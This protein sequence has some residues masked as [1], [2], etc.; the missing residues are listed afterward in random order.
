MERNGDIV[1][2][3]AREIAEMLARGEGRTDWAKVDATTQEE[4]ERQ[5]AEDDAELGIIW[6]DEPIV[7]LPAPR[8]AVHLAVDADVLDWF[9]SLGPG[10]RAR[11][12]AALRE[13]MASR[14]PAAG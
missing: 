12:N 13:F 10:Y 7:G 8:E 9:R 11:M 2:Y 5:A 14:K 3:S 6:E 4:I 1:R